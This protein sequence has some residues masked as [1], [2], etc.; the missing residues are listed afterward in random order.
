M[1]GKSFPAAVRLAQT[2]ASNWARID[3]AHPGVDL[4]TLP[5]RRWLN[6]VYVWA[7]EHMSDEDARAWEQKLNDPLPGEDA[8]R[9]DDLFDDSFNQIHQ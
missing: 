7:L 8:A 3:G 9:R 4:L 6:V 2:A 1:V 5:L